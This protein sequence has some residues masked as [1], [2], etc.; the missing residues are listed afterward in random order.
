MSKHSAGKGDTYRKLDMDKYRSEWERIFGKKSPKK[1][2][3]I[4]SPT[5]GLG[6]KK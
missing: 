1:L 6:K 2:K 4:P 5:F 3:Y